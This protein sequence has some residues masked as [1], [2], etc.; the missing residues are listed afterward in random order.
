MYKLL[1]ILYYIFVK[2]QTL[3]HFSGPSGT[4]V[5]FIVTLDLFDVF[6]HMPEEYWFRE[7]DIMRWMTASLVTAIKEQNQLGPRKR[8]ANW[9]PHIDP[10]SLILKSKSKSLLYGV[11][12]FLY[13]SDCTLAYMVNVIWTLVFNRRNTPVVL[14]VS[15]SDSLSTLTIYNLQSFLMNPPLGECGTNV[16]CC[17]GHV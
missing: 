11:I 3:Q 8:A 17:V 6:R 5:H 9:R 16:S 12:L 14:P 4:K 13:V 2:I 7:N 1:K 15:S 10:E